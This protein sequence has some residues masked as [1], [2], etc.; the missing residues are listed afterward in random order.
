MSS[1]SRGVSALTV[2]L[3]SI[4]ILIAA[5]GAVLF[6]STSVL[7]KGVTTYQKGG[8]AA[9]SLE[10]GPLPVQHALV[11][12]FVRAIY[13][14]QCA[15]SSQSFRDELMTLARDTEIN[16]L[17]ID[18]KDFSG[19]V[20]FPRD[21][22][23]EILSGNGC[24]VSDM[25]EF[26]KTLHDEG[27]Y[28]IGR[29]TV[30][31]DPLYAAAHPELAVQSKSKGVP[32]EDYKG[33]SFIDVG[34]QPFWDYIVDI[35]REAHAIGFDELNY[36]YIRFP[37]DGPMSDVQFNHSDYTQ[38]PAELEKF[39]RYLSLKVKKADDNGHIPILSA[40]L[41]GM[42]T[43][44]SDDLTIGQVLER[45]TPYFDYIAPMVY[46]SHYPPGF[47]GYTN[48]NN[49]VYGVVKYS[50]DRAVERV[51]ATSTEID[52]LAY[53]QIGTTTPAVFRKPARD[54][55]VLR[56]WLQD[57]DYGGDYGPTEVRAQIQAAYDAGLNSWMLW[58]PSNHYTRGALEPRQ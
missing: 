54:P 49:N 4:L 9:K 5:I 29:I 7:G 39:F 34:A 51:M 37:S 6:F 15:A 16:S 10:Q 57:F 32:W 22:G 14:S 45:T 24:K 25:K 36:D 56:P 28:V 38:R 19:T 8:I 48:P 35:S 18:I 33:L 2:L 21:E 50:M 40:D 30:F 52:A 44:N 26:I 11:P 55:N 1:F 41:F 23:A 46:P 12:E 43:T 17:I 20:S 13:M 58:A 3:S 31:Q 53:S 47:N 27:L 42:T